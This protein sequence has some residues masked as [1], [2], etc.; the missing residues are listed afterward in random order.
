MAAT[1]QVPVVTLVTILLPSTAHLLGVV[2][3][4]LTGSPEVAMA[5]AVVVLPTVSVEGG[6]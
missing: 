4:K 5:L 3:L 1:V 2:E 6:N